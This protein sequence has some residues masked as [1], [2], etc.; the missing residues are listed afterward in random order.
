MA[1]ATQPTRLRDVDFTDLYLHPGGQYRVRGLGDASHLTSLPDSVMGDFQA[2]CANLLSVAEKSPR[3]FT[4]PHDRIAYRISKIEAKSG[5]W[6]AIRKPLET[7]PELDA[8]RLPPGLGTTLSGMS[9]R[10]GLVLVSGATGAGKTTLAS[11][12]IR[13]WLA[14]RG[15]VGVTIEAPPELPLEGSHGPYGICFQTG[16]T[17][18]EFG[19]ALKR[20]MRWQPRYIFLGEIRTPAAAAIAIRAGV[21]GHL[22]LTT[23]HAGSP[24]EAIVA[25]AQLA[26]SQD[27]HLSRLGLASALIGVIHVAFDRASRHVRPDPLILQPS[28]DDPI[29]AKIRAGRYEQIST[30]LEN[31][32]ARTAPRAASR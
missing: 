17:E 24:I 28:L 8:L 4:C 31:Q 3:E 6:Y 27:P 18:D 5:T 1:T 20:A 11:A 19:D 29:R 12:L 23:L 21:T 7:V 16:V 30:E 22:V 15:D 2:F 9:Q 10:N 13:H 25:L 32:R 26:N 14:N